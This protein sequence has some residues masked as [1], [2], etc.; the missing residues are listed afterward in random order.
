MADDKKPVEVAGAEHTNTNTSVNADAEKDVQNLLAELKGGETA[1]PADSDEKKYS[2]PAEK[3]SEPVE[4]KTSEPVE[5]K[6]SEANGSGDAAKDEAAEEA[7]IVAAAAKLGEESEK[8]ANAS[9]GPTRGQ[10]RG[11]RGRGGKRVN[12]RDNI[13]SDLTSQQESSDPDAIRKQ[14]SQVLLLSHTVSE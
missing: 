12:Y 5:K 2:E 6:D 1:K 8:K 10:D 11:P 9:K 14:V 7:K 4:N 3:V 13:K